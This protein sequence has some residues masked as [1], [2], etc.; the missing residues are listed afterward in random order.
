MLAQ[1]DCQQDAYQQQLLR[2]HPTLYIQYDKIELFGQNH[3]FPFIHHSNTDTTA[4][5]PAAPVTPVVPERIIIPVVVHILWNNNAQNISDAQVLSQIDVLNKDYSGTNADRTKIPSYFST[6]AADCGIS[7]VLAKTDPQGLPTNGIL[8]KQTSTG[9]FSFDDKAK[10]NASNGDDAWSADNY[11]N[12]WV[13]NLVTGISGYA[14]APGGPKEKDGV[15]I[16][17][18]VFGTI[19]ISGPFN[20]GRTATHEIG[21]WLNLRHVWGDAYCGDDRVDDT[22][23]QQAANRGCNTGEKLTCGSTAHGDMYMNYMDFS[24]DACMYMFT[25]GQRSRMRVLFESG[26]P[27]NGLLFSNGLNGNGLPLKDTISNREAG[28]DLILYPNPALNAITV[29]LKENASSFGRKIIIYNRLGQIVMK[30]NCVSKLQ[31]LN[32][33]ALHTGLYFIKVDGVEGSR[34]KNFIK[35]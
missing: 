6:L 22:P 18:A 7:F 33:S 31:Q 4:G 25:K 1:N 15:V 2:L 14:S 17:T 24:D 29:Q 11:L 5:I 19:N 16:S 9:V 30:A 28:F 20:K 35:Q 8:R 34:M 3:L 12:I 27:R 32:I 26:G 21:H 23:T 10:S 13:C